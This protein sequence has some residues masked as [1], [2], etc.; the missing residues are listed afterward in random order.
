M[1]Q[2]MKRPTKPPF[3]KRRWVRVTSLVLVL[4]AAYGLYRAI[5]PDPNLKKV[6]QL[7]AEFA[8]AKNMTAEERQLKGREMRDAM[9]KLSQSQRQE[10]FAEGQKRMEEQY[11]RYAQMSQAEKTR[12]LDEQIKRS[13][14]MRQQFQ[15][16]PNTQRPQSTG[17][18]GPRRGQSAEER[19]KRRRE[20]LNNTSPE[21]RALRD[22][23]R[24]DLAARR[25]QWGLP[26]NGG[27]PRPRA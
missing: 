26:A 17:Q 9:S 1:H 2:L 4:V 8:Q 22:Q 23:Y 25:Q 24:K 10:L 20:R 14:Q 6:R 3:T 15:R 12:H 19:D 7:Q 16:N 18:G 21:F 27:G 11:K 13:E 5:R